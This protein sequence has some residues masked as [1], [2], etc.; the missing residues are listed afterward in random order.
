MTEESGPSTALLR[1]PSETEDL[2]ATLR[3]I[4]ER[5]LDLLLSPT[6]IATHRMVAAEMTRFPELGAI[7]FRSGPAR[8]LESL[9]AFLAAAMARG[10]LR[11]VPPCIAAAQFIELIRGELG[12]RAMLGVP[13]EELCGVMEAGVDTFLRAYTLPAP[14]DH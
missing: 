12:L 9:A 8:L 6:T 5:L 3:L 10:Q 13:V 11:E 4:A 14:P 1:L 2:P 7:F